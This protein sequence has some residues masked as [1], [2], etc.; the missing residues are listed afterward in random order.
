MVR[1]FLYAVA[2][3][4]VILIAGAF[5]LRIWGDDLAKTAFVPTSSF[6][7]Q[8]ALA[9]N[10]YSDTA[11]WLSHPR[12]TAATDSPSGRFVW[13]GVARRAPG[14]RRSSAEMDP[15]SVRR[16]AR[17][18]TFDSSRTLPGHG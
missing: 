9:G 5:A 15:P 8:D 12:F 6:V 17:S 10:A 3:F 18:M 11:M 7:Q 2:V 14:S 13:P 16:A 4:V 1:K